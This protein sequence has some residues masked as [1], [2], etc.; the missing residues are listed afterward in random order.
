M[1]LLM[2]NVVKILIGML[3]DDIG[4]LLQS[5]PF[6]YLGARVSGA[7]VNRMMKPVL[8]TTPFAW[9]TTLLITTCFPGVA[10]WLPNLL[11]G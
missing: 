6:L 8:I 4:G 10:L 11:L 5:V 2:V 9:L 3:M 1:I 7:P